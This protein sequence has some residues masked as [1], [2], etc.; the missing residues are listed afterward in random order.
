MFGFIFTFLI[1]VNTEPSIGVLDVA[2]RGELIVFTILL[3]RAEVFHVGWRLNRVGCLH[4]ASLVLICF[5]YL[6]S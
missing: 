3:S 1:D 5:L 4:L 2:V 6:G